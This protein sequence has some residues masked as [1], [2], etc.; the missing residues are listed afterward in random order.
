MAPRRIVLFIG[1]V[2]ELARA[3]LLLT[4]L[5]SLFG[6]RGTAIQP[7]LLFASTGNLLVPAAA[8]LLGAYPQRYARL[9][10]LLRLAKVLNLFALLLLGI[11]GLVTR[12]SLI[13]PPFPGTHLPGGVV[14]FLITAVD[15]LFLAFLASYKEKPAGTAPRANASGRMDEE[16]TDVEELH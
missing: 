12:S 6:Q 8:V 11:S 2:W 7:W 9:I 13:V 4:L 5:A 3:Y 14:V 16:A 10:G 15:A 1:S